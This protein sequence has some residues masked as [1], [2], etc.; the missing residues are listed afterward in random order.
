MG[1]K[2][3]FV[4]TSQFGVTVSLYQFEVHQSNFGA[5]CNN[6]K[7]FLYS[8]SYIASRNINNSINDFPLSLYL[9]F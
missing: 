2:F 1:R 3:T 5:S 9:H 7:I 8:D 6:Q 4:M